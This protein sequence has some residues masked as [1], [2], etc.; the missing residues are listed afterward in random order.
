MVHFK[1]KYIHQTSFDRSV[2]IKLFRST[3]G[4]F[5]LGDDDDDKVDFNKS[6]RIGCMAT[7]ESICT[8]RR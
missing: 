7:K 8:W 6:P 3:K 1:A 4:L 5:A 2:E